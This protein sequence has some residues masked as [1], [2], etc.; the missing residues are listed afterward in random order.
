[1]YQIAFRETSAGKMSG[2]MKKPDQRKMHK[3]SLLCVH[4][5]GGQPIDKEL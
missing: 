2:L 5:L 4:I 3:E 1:M